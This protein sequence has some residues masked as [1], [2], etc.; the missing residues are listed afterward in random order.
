V[1][2]RR[3][4]GSALLAR[5]ASAYRHARSGLLRLI[6]RRINVKSLRG[7]LRRSDGPRAISGG[8]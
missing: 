1:Y 6:F 7:R 4:A 8:R 2:G 5:I 3:L